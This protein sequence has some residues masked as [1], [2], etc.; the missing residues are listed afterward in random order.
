MDRGRCVIVEVWT[1]AEVRALR[2]AALRMTQEQ[3]AEQ[4]G[5]AVA[6]VRK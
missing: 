1:R 5:W 3:F 6:T 4:I 2:D